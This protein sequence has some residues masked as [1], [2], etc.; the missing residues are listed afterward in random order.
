MPLLP[1]ISALSCV[2][3]MATLAVETWLRFLAWLVDRP[4]D[5]L[6]LRPHPLTAGPGREEAVAKNLDGDD[7]V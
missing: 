2:A 5:L 1:I 7:V 4:G 3:L 6:L